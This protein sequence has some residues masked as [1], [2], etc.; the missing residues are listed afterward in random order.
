MMRLFTP[1]I[2]HMRVVSEAILQ[3]SMDRGIQCI[4][5]E[6][7]RN[8]HDRNKQFV[9]FCVGR[10][11]FHL[12]IPEMYIFLKYLFPESLGEVKCDLTQNST[13]FFYVLK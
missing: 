6:N 4:N 12:V 1:V 7:S 13:I 2:L 11:L 5:H 10:I 8:W 9:E 3:H